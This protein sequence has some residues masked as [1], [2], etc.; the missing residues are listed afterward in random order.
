[1]V[2]SG[3]LS[4]IENRN[5]WR[6][7]NLFAMDFTLFLI[8]ILKYFWVSNQT[9]LLMSVYIVIVKRKNITVPFH[10]DLQTL[11]EPAS[12]ALVPS[13]HVHDTVI[14]LFAYVL[15]IPVKPNPDN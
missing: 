13:S 12:L 14:V 7:Q 2:T 4:P 15:Q 1:M 9:K 8:L 5:R 10:V 6:K 3:S 11:F